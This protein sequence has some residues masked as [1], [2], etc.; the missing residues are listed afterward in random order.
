MDGE[1]IGSGGPPS[2]EPRRPVLVFDGQCGFC[3]RSVLWLLPRFRR[4]VRAVPYQ[5]ADLPALG[6][7]EAETRR[8]AWWIDEDGRRHRGHRA[9]ARALLAC[10]SPWPP[11]GR[12]LLLPPPV[13][14]L[15]AAAYRLIA[16]YR[17]FLPGAT[18]AC[19]RPG[20]WP[21]E[22]SG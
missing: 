10:R 14:W 9:M 13:S 21:P 12:A 3:T 20:G 17:R 6:L 1:P 2:F 8:Y 16:R 19:R 18:P 7:T 11:L 15:A 4:P 5:W 22:H